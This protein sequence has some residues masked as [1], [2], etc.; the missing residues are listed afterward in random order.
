MLRTHG[1]AKHNLCD[2]PFPSLIDRV[3]GIPLA[4]RI[5]NAT[6]DRSV[7]S[8]YLYCAVSDRIIGDSVLLGVGRA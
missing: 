8:N 5:S 6:W 3:E 4:D 2:R 7:S 1:G